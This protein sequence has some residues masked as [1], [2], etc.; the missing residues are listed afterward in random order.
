[1]ADNNSSTATSCRITVH[2]PPNSPIYKDIVKKTKGKM[3]NAAFMRMAVTYYLDQI[4][5][6]KVIF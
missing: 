5:K 2:F 1:M 6:G 3:D 4:E